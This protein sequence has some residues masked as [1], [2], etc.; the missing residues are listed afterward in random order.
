M[1][2]SV[3]VPTL[4]EGKYLKKCLKSIRAQDTNLDYELI[5][6]DSKSTDCTLD[7]AKKYADQFLS[8]SQTGIWIGRNKGAAV[9]KG[10]VFV[11]VDADTQIPK[12]YIDVVYSVLKDKKVSG[13]SCAFKFDKHTKYLRLIEELSNKYLLFKGSIGKGEILGFNNAV[14]KSIFMKA[15]GFPD[16]PLEDGAFAIELQKHGRVVYL[17]E[18]IVITSARRFT[19]GNTLKSIIYYANLTV[20]PRFSNSPLKTLIKYKK[21]IPIR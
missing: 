9:A 1:D 16:A 6:V 5:V 2:V 13:L 15:G 19:R 18:P 10:D 17:P 8:I 7:I 20:A 4:N 21:Y 12:N 14:S 3:I 11:F